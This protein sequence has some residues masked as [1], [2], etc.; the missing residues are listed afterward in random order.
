MLTLVYCTLE[1]LK[2]TKLGISLVLHSVHVPL[3][4]VIVSSAKGK[5]MIFLS[6]YSWQHNIFKNH[7]IWLRNSAYNMPQR[8][9][10]KILSPVIYGSIQSI[11]K[12]ISQC[13]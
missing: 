11:T 7:L 3:E 13:C 1:N 9:R 12:L 10:F 5:H 8:N 6:F 2:E 4:H